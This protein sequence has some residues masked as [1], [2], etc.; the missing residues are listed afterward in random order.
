L[1]RNRELDSA[2]IGP[3]RTLGD[4]HL[5]AV[6]LGNLWIV[7]HARGDADPAAPLLEESLQLTRKVGDAFL[8]IDALAYKG[9]AECRDGNLEAQ[10]RVFV[11]ASRSQVS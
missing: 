1:F 3:V 10:K 7:V 5:L 6:V 2:C 8:E 4:K 9:R 11:Q